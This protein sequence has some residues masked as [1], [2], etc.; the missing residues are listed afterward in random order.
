MNKHR[1]M[2][3]QSSSGEREEQ[4]DEARGELQERTEQGERHAQMLKVE[5]KQTFKGFS[6]VVFR[7]EAYYWLYFLYA[8][9]AVC[10]T[11]VFFAW[12]LVASCLNI[13]L[14]KAGVAKIKRTSYF[15][16]IIMFGCSLIVQD[17]DFLDVSYLYHF[18]RGQNTVKLYS[19]GL[20]IMIFEIMLTTTGK[21]YLGKIPKILLNS[22]IKPS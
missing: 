5:L 13:V 10:E 3:V 1:T 14:P 19:V 8:V 20:S 21:M 11:I 22:E 12:D 9:A 6:M 4:E 15:A 16:C 17:L 2:I 18:F 7:I